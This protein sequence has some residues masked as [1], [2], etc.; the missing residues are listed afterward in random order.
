VVLFGVAPALHFSRVSILIF[1]TSI[2][3]CDGRSAAASEL[4]MHRI[5][6]TGHRAGIYPALPS[7]NHYASD[8]WLAGCAVCKQRLLVGCTF[9]TAAT[10][11]AAAASNA[12]TI[13]PRPT[14]LSCMLWHAY[15]AL[16]GPLL[17]LG[18]TLVMSWVRSV[19]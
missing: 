9:V 1:V 4:A 13:E 11:V 18:N 17:S 14:R 19:V 5:H 8:E 6:F 7:L 2:F 16:L 12:S 10:A 15:F 3:I